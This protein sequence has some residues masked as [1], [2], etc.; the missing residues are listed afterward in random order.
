M[1][2]FLFS[3][4]ATGL[5]SG[6]GCGG[7]GT[8]GTGGV[9]TTGSDVGGGTATST[10]HGGA[11]T[12]SASTSTSTTTT[13]AAATT[14]TGS[15][16]GGASTTG[17]GGGSTASSSATTAA[18]T[19][20][21]S[22]SSGTGGAPGC[23][24][25]GVV[26]PPEQC[27]DGNATDGDGCDH[28]CTFS[29]VDPVGDCPAP[30]VCQ[31][32]ACLASHTCA[33]AADPA[34]EGTSCGAN[35]LCK[36]GACAPITC[37][38]GVVQGTE[39][40]DFG[41]GNGPGTG[42]ETTCT[43]SCT[44]APD[45]C[46]NAETCD[47]V[48]SCTTILSGAS[49]GQK[50]AP[51][52][53]QPSC[54]AC[55]SGVCASGVCKASTCGDGCLDAA[56]GEQCEPP[57][58]VTCDA[59]CKTVIIPGCGNGVREPGEQ[60]DDGNLVNLDGCDAT[61]AFEQDLRT[62]YLQL[63]YG[64]DAFCGN[65]NQLGAAV[66][67]GVP[68]STLQTNL[69][70][71]IADGSSGF[72]I[73]MLGLASLT[74][75]DDPALEVGTML[76]DPVP[77]A[78]YNG[79]NDLEW[80]YNVSSTSLD[81]ARDPID[82]LPGNITANVLTAGPGAMSLAV[83]F[84]HTSPIALRLTTAKLQISVGASSIPGSSAGGTPGHLAS[85][86]LA[87]AIQSFAMLGQSSINLAGKLCGNAGAKFLSQTPIPS[88]LLP[89]G[90]YACTQGYSAAASFLDVIVSGCTINV[91]FAI[92]LIL[93]T[94]PDKADPAAP[95]A[96]AGA[97]YKLF[98]NA[99]KLVTSCTDKNNVPAP[100]AACIAAAAYSTYFRFAMDRVILK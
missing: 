47:G 30:P 5:V 58:T 57:G 73:K 27:D 3:L 76:G 34:Q 98:A 64:L 26:T 42:C 62:N 49:V 95:V 90:A 37:G 53:Q 11:T 54:T 59:A 68:Q 20:G 69:D 65:A 66:A 40:C 86:H 94:Q 75:A 21:S 77:G 10:G 25:D 83:N 67:P 92:P 29:C 32:S 71:G 33:L 4:V 18:G 15:G 28:D 96:G 31:Q 8:S 85:E 44:K 61:C 35:A 84:F 22:T 91:G 17:V 51:G 45:S 6:V 39:Q 7:T 36:A 80:W 100:V 70:Q 60:C 2:R 56:V 93:P 41:A 19:T 74:G 46:P 89:G 87:P 88:E 78:G 1:K 9:S 48:E 55:A 52:I 79:A 99:Q 24:L 38:D 72:V 63:Q 82:K 97:P 43:F 12:T 50:C 14:A 13:T 23:V 81:A 16:G